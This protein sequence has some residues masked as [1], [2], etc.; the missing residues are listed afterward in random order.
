MSIIKCVV[1]HSDVKDL[2]SSYQ[3]KYTKSIACESCA[4]KYSKRDLEILADLFLMYGGYE[5][6]LKAK[7][8]SFDALLDGLI[9]KIN[10]L[11]SERNIDQIF[12]MT[13]HHLLLHGMDPKKLKES[14]ESS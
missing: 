7:V 14:I 2:K 10:K 8:E 3:T 6:K 12:T 13:L 1:C 11:P 5:G 4:R 9:D